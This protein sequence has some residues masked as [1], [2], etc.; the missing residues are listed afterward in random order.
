[1]LPST[2]AATLEAER[3][4]RRRARRA[5]P[6]GSPKNDS[7]QRNDRPGGGN[8]SEL[9]LENDIG[10]TTAIGRQRNRSTAPPKTASRKR[11]TRGCRRGGAAISAD[12]APPRQRT[13]LASRTD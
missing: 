6:A 12:A 11:P 3:H 1:M 7:Y 10:T 2:S 8:A 9:A 4:Q 5:Q 13:A